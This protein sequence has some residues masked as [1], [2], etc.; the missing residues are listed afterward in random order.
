MSAQTIH[1]ASEP[2]PPLVPR[3]FRLR[4]DP[5]LLLA[6]L[7]LAACS[8]IVLRGATRNDNDADPLFYVKRQGVYIVVG[9]ILMYGVSRIDYSRL[10]ELRY[11]IYGAL[12][13]I[14]LL[15]L[16]IAPSTRGPRAPVTAGR[17]PGRPA[18]VSRAS[19]AK[20]AASMKSGSSPSTAVLSTAIPGRCADRRPA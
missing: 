7:G 18:S 8:L 12:I 1:P 5:L 14:L 9:L 4:L 2:P 20:P 6:T 19:Q 15:V 13:A 11:P 3:E 10:R 16:A 17:L